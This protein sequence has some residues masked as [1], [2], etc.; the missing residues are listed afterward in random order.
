M[1]F[2]VKGMSCASCQAHVEKAVSSI[3]G[4]SSCTVS[5][6]TN[7]MKVEGNV[8]SNVIIEAV[9]KAGY[10]AYVQGSK[11]E[12]K[13]DDSK[14]LKMKLMVSIL[15]LFLLMYISMGHT[16]F[17]LPVP[18]FMNN[19]LILAILQMLLTI[20]IMILNQKFFI[21]GIKGILNH[22][23]NMDTLVSLGSFSS[24]I[25]SLY[26]VFKMCTLDTMDAMSILHG[27]YFESASMILVLI[28]VGKL[29]EERSKGKTT[30][31]IQS[32]MNLKPKTAIKKINNEEVIV[33]IDQIQIGDI[34][35]CKPGSQIPVDGIVTGGNSAV[36]ESSLT[37]E[38]LPVDKEPG[39]KVYAATLN[40]TGYIE[41][42]ATR[43]G[44]D[45]TLSQ[46]IQMVQDASASKAPIAKVADKVSSV[47][48]PIVI[49]L[50]LLT[51][52]GW[53]F[54]GRSFGFSLERAICVLVISCPCSLGLAT[55]VA[56]MV[57]NGMG[58]KN[59]ILFK[60]STALEQT[61]K[62][63]IVAL[64]KTGTITKGHPVVSEIHPVNGYSQ[65]ELLTYACSLESYSE[66][67]LAYAILEKGKEFD[68]QI[69]ETQDFMSI[70][71]N[72]IQ[73]KI[74]NSLFMAGSVSFIQK[75]V[76]I[77]INFDSVSRQG[78]TP[79]LFLKDN[80]LMGYISIEDEM[81]EDAIKAIE[82][83][84]ELNC[85]VV[86]LTGDNEL[87]ANAI[88]QKAGVDSIYAQLLPQDKET[89]VQ[90][91]QKEGKVLMVGDGINDAPALT[92]A[93]IGMAMG[94]GV[95]VAIDAADVVCMHPKLEDVCASIRLS[96]MTL[97][98]IYENLFWA[99]I[100]NILGIPLA[101]GLFG[102]NLNPMIAAG[103]MSVSSLCVVSNALRLNTKKLYKEEKR[104]NKT[105]KINGMMCPHCQSMVQKTLEKIDG[106]TQADVSFKTGEAKITLSKEVSDEILKSAIE[107]KDY[108]VVS[109]R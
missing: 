2:I 57:G 105:I 18:S 74:E 42:Q 5:L 64:D 75:Y 30:N 45:T 6:L 76:D 39:S 66:H 44:K 77:D 19:V 107:Q 3:D 43:V 14:N 48:V 7:S 55:P 103:M 27:L 63:N 109:I 100:Y 92:R 60:N 11:E 86:M 20:C 41:C 67:P 15:L 53:L 33:D 36:D 37:G 22:S 101:M 25:Y 29:L 78:K 52:F 65:K 35:I 82:H 50:A 26:L 34:F 12:I 51:L 1:D 83:L 13:V 59:G 70:T 79:V 94:Q 16:M 98:N 9:S 28:S 56:I 108:E 10:S 17:H 58:A 88:G 8:S 89:I 95:D 49:G 102:W 31:A 47:F 24:F 106:V 54:A 81:K 68:I 97:K 32:L 87:T 69:K 46:I 72:G 80:K 38:S 4:V 93:N 104:M 73:G 96:K 40:Q 85:K 23:M 91:L 99:F 21:N 71:G 61:G 84:H 62:M 90:M